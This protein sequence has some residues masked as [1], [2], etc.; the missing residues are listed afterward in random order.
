MED[1]EDAAVLI[2]APLQQVFAITGLPA[3]W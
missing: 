2:R 1:A 3:V